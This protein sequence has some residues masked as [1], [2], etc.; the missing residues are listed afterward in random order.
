MTTS[1][2]SLDISYF[3]VHGPDRWLSSCKRGS[4][5]AATGKPDR[6][7]T[8]EARRR[9]RGRY[10]SRSLVTSA[11]EMRFADGAPANGGAV[12]RQSYRCDGPVLTII[13]S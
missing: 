9:P 7:F 4:S 10:N 11:M 2:A 5:V 3:L 12:G 1:N 8:L 6:R 13:E